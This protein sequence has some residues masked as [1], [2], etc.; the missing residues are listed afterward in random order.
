MDVLL[1]FVLFHLL[2]GVPTQ[3]WMPLGVFVTCISAVQHAQLDWRFGPLYR[4]LVSPRFHAYHHSVEPDHANANYGF[5]FSFWD[6]L[7][8]TAVAEQP[9]PTR[10]GVDGLDMG[11]RLTTHLVNPFRLLW[12]SASAEVPAPPAP[13]PSV[14]S[15]AARP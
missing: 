11:E 12:G 8:G 9:R 14:E 6:Y 1:Y 3:S 2:L 15:P 7:F 10:F 4:V 13:A 5:L